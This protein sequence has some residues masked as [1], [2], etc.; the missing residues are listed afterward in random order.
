MPIADSSFIF[1]GLSAL[2]HPLLLSNNNA[3]KFGTTS[4]KRTG[5][6]DSISSTQ[7]KFPSLR[8]ANP[9]LARSVVAVLG[10][11]FVDAGY[12]GDWSRIGAITKETED[13]LKIGAF[14]VVPF[15]VFLIFSFSEQTD[16][17]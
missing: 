4:A 13:L 14:L 5:D 7:L 10:L 17:S 3:R 15:C 11:G 6:S 2:P 9:L 12:S 8:V 16:S 1:T